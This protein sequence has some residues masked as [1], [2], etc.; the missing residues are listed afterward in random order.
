MENRVIDRKRVGA[1][2]LCLSVLGVYLGNIGSYGLLEPDE[3]RY[4]EIPREMIES[5]DYITPRLNYV[6]Y[7]EKPVLQYW[8]T[9]LSFAVFGQTERAQRLFPVAMALLGAWIAWRIASS[10]YGRR[11]ASLSAWILLTSLIYFAIS[12]INILDMA[13]STFIVLSLAG[14]W[15]FSSGRESRGSLTLFYVGM[16]LATLTKGLIGFVLPGGIVLLYIAATRQWRLFRYAFWIP[17]I[18]IFLVLTLPWFYLVCRANPDFFDFF[19]VREHFL[20]YATKIHDRYQPFWFFVPI[21]FLGFFP[22]SGL[23]PLALFQTFGR[24]RKGLSGVESSC[25]L[26]LSIWA[27]VVFIFFSLSGSK[28]IPYIVPLLPPLGILMAKSLCDLLDSQHGGP[29]RWLV[30]STSA[31]DILIIA[32]GILYPIFDVKDGGLMLLPHTLPLV[33]ACSIQLVLLAVFHR[34]RKAEALGVSLVVT[35]LMIIFSLHWG[36]RFLGWT[37]SEKDTAQVIQAFAEPA[38]FLAQ[39]GDYGQGIP[40]YLNRRLALVNSVGELEFGAAQEQDPQWF[41]DDD[42]LRRRWRGDRRVILVVPQK[43]HGRFEAL[44]LDPRPVL[45]GQSFR[46]L[47]YTNR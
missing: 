47:V 16:A 41:M 38:D 19:F 40:F 25:E 36:Y 1:L 24:L 15:F 26:Y 46:N 32:A 9:A 27:G 12:Q 43:E 4:S 23:L 7:F 21:V 29:L 28:L 5:G 22:W 10:V 11:V 39:Y 37:R 13:V 8:A 20:R 17:G 45:R 33:A 2:L 34:R 35:A 42:A 18:A 14:F 6:K 31:L 30:Y 3:G 44:L